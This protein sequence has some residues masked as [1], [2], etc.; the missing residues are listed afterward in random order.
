MV[1]VK[2]KLILLL[3]VLIAAFSV[4]EAQLTHGTEY[5]VREGKEGDTVS[6]IV[7]FQ[8]NGEQSMYISIFLAADMSPSAF[9]LDPGKTQDVH[10]DYTIPYG[11]D[12]GTLFIKPILFDKKGV[13]YNYSVILD[14]TVL[15]TPGKNY[16]FSS[17]KLTDLKTEPETINPNE[18]FDLVFTINNPIATEPTGT[19]TIKSDFDFNEIPVQK[20]LNGVHE[21]RISNL[22]V[23]AQTKGQFNYTLRIIMQD[24]LLDTNSVFNIPE[25]SDCQVTETAKTGIVGRS[26]SAEI[27]NEGTGTAACAV[28][29]KLFGLEKYLVKSVSEGY[30]YEGQNI[31]WQVS[32]GPAQTVTVNYSVTYWPIIAIPFVILVIVIAFWYL[33]RKMEIKKELV[34]YRRHAGFT[35]LKLQVHVKNLS[36]NEM[37][38][39]KI[40]DYLPAFV[41][42]IRD[43]GTVPGTVT[44]K[45][46]VKAV[47]WE[48]DVLKPKEERIFS[49]K[50][51]TSVVI[52]GKMNFQP[53]AVEY[54]NA[55]G[56]K[57]QETSNVLSVEV[58]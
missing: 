40:Y 35:D 8:N 25:F 4:A 37:A 44:A 39:V 50:I 29:S 11:S 5:L 10:I 18:P 43:F 20:I 34:D 38:H 23:P 52:L 53:T 6:Y 2:S 56:E 36:N 7:T 22:S 57:V 26:Y 42:E 17:V 45:D 48:L 27:Y 46:G 12:P 9:T 49:Y 54:I 19:F 58:D 21:Y 47:K 15:P 16:K 51:R 30:A 3:I 28:S 32:V 24:T 31:K 55:K 41:K 13:R 14:A 33:T 1:G